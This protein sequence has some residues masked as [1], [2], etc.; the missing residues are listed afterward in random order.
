MDVPKYPFEI[1]GLTKEEGGGY[2]I[3]FPDMPGC[4]SDGETVEEAIHTGRTRNGPGWQRR[5]NGKLPFL[6]PANP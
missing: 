3:T 2:L 1:R 5:Q 4:M 6:S